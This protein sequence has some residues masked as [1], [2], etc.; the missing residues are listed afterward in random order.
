MRT[1]F[2]V[3]AGNTVYEVESH[4]VGD[5]FTGASP[6]HDFIRGLYEAEDGSPHEMFPSRRDTLSFLAA[7]GIDH[8]RVKYVRI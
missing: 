1:Y 7:R 4:P 5:A 2:W 3:P 6:T 8:T